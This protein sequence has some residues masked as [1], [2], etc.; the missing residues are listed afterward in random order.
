MLGSAATASPA[1]AAPATD[2]LSV[3]NAYRNAAGIQPVA[4]NATLGAGDGKHSRY[5]VENG[6]IQHSEDAS[7]RWYTPEGDDAARNSNLQMASAPKIQVDAVDE[8]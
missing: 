7:N 6:V 5:M 4:E 2:W 1:A 3:L 8:W